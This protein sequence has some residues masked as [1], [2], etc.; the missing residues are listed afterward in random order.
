[1]E[2][3]FSA[4]VAAAAAAQRDSATANLL[5]DYDFISPLSFSISSSLYS[6]REISASLD[7]VISGGF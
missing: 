3:S 5:Y 2:K 1:M 4:V 6:G 7:L